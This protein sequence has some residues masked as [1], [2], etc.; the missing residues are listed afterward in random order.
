MW[1]GREEFLSHYISFPYGIFQTS[2][3]RPN[4]I[5]N[6]LIWM[7]ICSFC[8]LENILLM[9][10]TCSESVLWR[11]ALLSKWQTS[12]GLWHGKWMYFCFWTVRYHRTRIFSDV[13]S[14]LPGLQASGRPKALFS[15]LQFTQFLVSSLLIFKK[16]QTFWSFPKNTGFSLLM[17]IQIFGK[18]YFVLNGCHNFL[19]LL[20]FP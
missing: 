19:P 7:F 15:V 1:I 3:W 8:P 5:K 10:P 12:H 20:C 2:C 4:I 16:E 11:E 18:S 17:W 14:Y 6:V 13:C 9:L